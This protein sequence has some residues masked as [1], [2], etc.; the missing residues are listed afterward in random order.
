MKKDKP[1]TNGQDKPVTLGE[2]EWWKVYGQLLEYDQQIQAVVAQAQRQV[3][4]IE[5]HRERML[6]APLRAKYGFMEGQQLT[7]D[8][9]TLSLKQADAPVVGPPGA[10]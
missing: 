5:Q 2:L 6:L 7:L 10:A 1:H 8:K 4:Q 3:Q 9:A